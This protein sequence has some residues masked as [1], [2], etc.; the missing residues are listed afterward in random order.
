MT[1]GSPWAAGG[2]ERL[3]TGTSYLD[4]RIALEAGYDPGTTGSCSSRFPPVDDACL[5]A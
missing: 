4:L 3:R 2:A 1:P 5:T